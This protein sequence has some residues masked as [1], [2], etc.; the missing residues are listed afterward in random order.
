MNPS[1][2]GTQNRPQY[3][4]PAYSDRYPARAQSQADPHRQFAGPGPDDDDTAWY[5]N[6]DPSRRM[7]AAFPINQTIG[8]GPPPNQPDFYRQ[9]PAASR[10]YHQPRPVQRFAS[11]PS[12]YQT[13][14]Y[15]NQPPPADVASTLTEI[16]EMQGKILKNQAATQEEME[17]F[18]KRMDNMSLNDTDAKPLGRSF[19]KASKRAPSRASSRAQNNDNDADVSN[20]D[21]NENPKPSDNITVVEDLRREPKFLSEE[22]GTVR[23]KI[24]SACR[25][26][27]RHL[28]GLGK[29]D[30]WVSLWELDNPDG[31][32]YNVVT[33][34]VYLTPDFHSDV[35]S[36]YND[37][38]LRQVAQAGYELVQEMAHSDKDFKNPRYKW[39]FDTY[40]KLT[41]ATFNGFKRSYKRQPT[42][43][44]ARHA[45]SL[46]AQSHA[47]R[48]ARRTHK[49]QVLRNGVDA[50][51]RAHPGSKPGELL[52]AELMSD[53]ASGPS[54]VDQPKDEWKLFMAQKLGFDNIT[55]ETL[56]K[57][58][59]LENIDPIW[60]SDELGAV[61]RELERLAEQSKKPGGI[62]K[63]YHRV[64]DTGRRTE[65]P[66]KFSPHNFGISTTWWDWYGPDGE[67]SEMY[68]DI[69]EAG[70]W[71]EFPD[72]PGFGSNISTAEPNDHVPGVEEASA[73]NDTGPQALDAGILSAAVDSDHGIV[74]ETQPGHYGIDTSAVDPLTMAGFY[75]NPATG[76]YDDPGPAVD[77]YDDPAAGIWN[78]LMDALPPQDQT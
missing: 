3:R 38:F 70:H 37:K 60:R 16:K 49:C 74:A 34:E 40:L 62:Q 41:K 52:N 8:L 57:M 76:I 32:R 55:Q 20:D 78:L 10:P 5:R 22:A 29:H 73:T 17:K 43:D 75:L 26:E 13:V 6:D 66:P 58:H 7:P 65:K 33:D 59:F 46:V 30:P 9:G 63:K 61:Y 2:Q 15:N 24:Q 1:G 67:H 77:V 39:S 14:D 47:R 31:D 35:D 25:S 42:V 12:T 28:C 72:P 48:R 19:T 18:K 27:M 36:T 53:D 21:N 50:Y 56:D 64:T 45:E 71:Y 69:I 4:A 23:D 11:M 51:I 44:P 68:R 54:D